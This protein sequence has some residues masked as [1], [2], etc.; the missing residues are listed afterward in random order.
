MEGVSGYIPTYGVCEESWGDTRVFLIHGRG[1][2]PCSSTEQS[3]A[4]AEPLLNLPG[5]LP[6]LTASVSI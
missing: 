1:W 4:V 6:R 3:L 5:S 2:L